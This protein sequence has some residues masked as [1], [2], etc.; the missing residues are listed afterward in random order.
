MRGAKIKCLNCEDVI[1][2]LDVNHFVTCNCTNKA[3]ALC[4]LFRG[5]LE[6][7]LAVGITLGISEACGAFMEVINKG[8]AVDGGDDYLRILGNPGSYEILNDNE[9]E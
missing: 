6:R 4:R 9:G 8:V 7:D 1:R 5:I 2:S 3:K